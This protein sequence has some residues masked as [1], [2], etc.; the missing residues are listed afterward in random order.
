MESCPVWGQ[1]RAPPPTGGGSSDGPPPQGGRGYS[2]ELGSWRVRGCAGL[3]KGFIFIFTRSLVGK[4]LESKLKVVV[5]L[6]LYGAS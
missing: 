5:L 1:D 2:L 4:N 6:F 3:I